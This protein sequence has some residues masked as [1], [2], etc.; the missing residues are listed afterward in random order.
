M[1]K[2]VISKPLRTAIG[3]FGG[4]LKDTSAVDLGTTVVKEIIKSSKLDP[5]EVDDCIMGNILGAG[6]GQN[7]S[8]QIAINS[9]LGVETPA[10]TLNRL[11]GSGL[12]SVVFAAQVIKA[13]DADCIV[14]GGM[15]NMSQAPF[16]LKKARWG[17]KMA[18]PSE[19]IID[20]MVYDGLWDVFGDY[21]MGI[22]A[23]N[24]AEQYKI[25]RQQQ[26]EF[27]YNSQLK[28]KHAQ[29][30]GKFDDQIVPVSIPKRKGDSTQFKTDEHPRPDVTI[31]SLS[32]LK[33]V[34]KKDGTVTAGSA[35][36]INDG[37]AAM[38]VCSESKAK[39]LDLKPLAF[40]RSYGLAGV[41]PSVMGIGPV[42]AIQKAL[43]KAGL[44]IDDIDLIELNEAFAAQ[45]LACLSD[46]PIAAE[47]LNVN[48]GAIALGH[49]IGA[50]GTVILVKLL[51]EMKLRKEAK[52]GLCSL[53]IGGG[54]GIAMIVEKI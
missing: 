1:E 41:D 25:S 36:G 39:N 46:L 7:P 44:S 20:G 33:P 31:D 35:S 11:C 2:I 24:L 54:M 48:G 5:K 34:F 40:I 13:G 52:I 32:K 6:L 18:M 19:E 53:C 28:T 3:T 47:K 17:Y 12:Q 51:H 50:S 10:T 26:D 29:E 49:P 9:G 23:E 22:T 27:A 30:N 8:R 14:A 16:Y 21:H 45:S 38:I 43:S 37:A 42:P 4:T 15:E